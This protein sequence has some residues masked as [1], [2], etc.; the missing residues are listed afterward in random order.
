MKAI[1]INE[2]IENVKNIVQI[3]N[4]FDFI[5]Y[6]LPKKHKNGAELQILDLDS[7]W[8]CYEVVLMEF[9]IIWWVWDPQLKVKSISDVIDENII[10]NEV[11]N[12]SISIYNYAPPFLNSD[13]RF[14]VVKAYKIF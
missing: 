7:Q 4:L 6:E 1:E 14:E 9:R 12:Y 2:F 10:W 11:L 13:W 8:T 3:D 5:W